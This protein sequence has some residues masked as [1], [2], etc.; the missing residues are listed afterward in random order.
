MAPPEADAAVL[1][2]LRDRLGGNTN[3]MGSR[4]DINCDNS[5]VQL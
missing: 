5:S 2:P 1:F 4:P 3:T